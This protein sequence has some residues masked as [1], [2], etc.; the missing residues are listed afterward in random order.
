MDCSKEIIYED[1]S[2]IVVNKNPGVAVI[3]GRGLRI[4]DSL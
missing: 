3:S 1:D 2:V 4:R